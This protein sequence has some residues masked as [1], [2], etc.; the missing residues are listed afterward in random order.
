MKL[1]PELQAVTDGVKL[2]GERVLIKRFD[3]ENKVGLYV[4]G[5]KMEKG[6]VVAVGQGRFQRRKVAFKQGTGR[7][8]QVTYFED[9]AYTGR[10][11]PMEV[12]VGDV[13]EFSPR[14]QDERDFDRYGFLGAGILV[15]VKQP[16]IYCIDM[17][18]S[19]SE[20]M[21]WQQSAGYDR[22]GRF[23]SGA[24]AWA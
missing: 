16:S 2:L 15:F 8:E 14:L 19:K 17:D 21:L 23:M 3:Y 20:G 11:R 9:G 7:Y 5:V 12:K 18:E 4:A 1:P 6:V 13:V 22:E 10:M 24:E